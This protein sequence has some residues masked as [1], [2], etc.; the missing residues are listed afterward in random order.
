MVLVWDDFYVLSETIDNAMRPISLG[1]RGCGL[2]G[3]H[4]EMASGVSA[5]SCARKAHSYT[6]VARKCGMMCSHSEGLE[7]M[8]GEA[9]KRSKPEDP[10]DEKA[11]QES[12]VQPTD[13][14]S[15]H[16]V[17]LSRV[18]YQLRGRVEWYRDRWRCVD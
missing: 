4:Y 13:F 8:G 5:L 10:K 3:D 15:G 12:H 14:G 9:M 17:E 18:S 6:I 1:V 11:G 7:P 2:L 16:V